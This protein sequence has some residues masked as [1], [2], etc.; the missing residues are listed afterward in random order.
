MRP[1]VL[2]PSHL[3]ESKNYEAPRVILGITSLFIAV[4]PIEMRGLLKLQ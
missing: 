2:R 4:T 1:I 3:V